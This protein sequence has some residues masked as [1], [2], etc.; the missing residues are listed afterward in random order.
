MWRA[1]P[2]RMLIGM[3]GATETGASKPHGPG[4]FED[5]IKDFWA[6]RPRRPQ[7]GRKIAGVAAAVGH[8]YGIDPVIVRVALVA[9]TLF[10]GIGLLLYLLGWLVFPEERDEVSAVEG[11]LGRGRTS[12][13]HG[14]T[15]LL[16]L[17]LIPV[18]SWAFSGDWFGT[19]VGGS[20]IIGL[21]LFVGALYLL[22][23]SR[24]HANRP[25]EPAREA[26]G[27]GFTA[28]FSVA[29][30]SG[31][32]R[33]TSAST[34]PPAWD[35]LGAAP[36]AWDLPDPAPTPSASPPPHPTRE[37]RRSRI[38]AATF[39]IALLVAGAGIALAVSG[40]AWFSPQHIVGLTLAVLGIGMVAGSFVRGGRGLIGLAVL[41][42]IA[43][44]VL[45]AVPRGGL[46][47]GFGDL[48]ATPLTSAEVR[49]VYEHSAGDLTL[50]LTR[51]PANSAPV[52]TSVS[53]GVG[54][55][56]VLVPATAD[57]QY[58][59]DTAAGRISCL[60]QE[61]SGVGNDTLSD[62]NLGTDGAGGTRITLHVDNGAGDVEVRRG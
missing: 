57:V 55:T 17:A 18:T 5:I 59:C 51:L 45:T 43:G 58:T 52:T 47:G 12:V 3:S 44:L 14:Y 15:V 56:T 53:N 30:D 48:T 1:A 11:L 60:G 9:G 6:S 4:G 27:S 2:E 29:A 41:V 16:C 62:R 35:P 25:A 28:E 36:L 33:T 49:P 19:G 23:R 22:H 8:R 13:S 37:G 42:S 24:G 20:G 7:Q 40:L 61:R 39:G 50:D 46:S 26:A 38:G 21:A 31:E 10:G 34:A 54:R 32:A